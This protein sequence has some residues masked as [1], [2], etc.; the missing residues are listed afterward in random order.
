MINF[1]E[2]SNIIPAKVKSYDVSYIKLKQV[3]RWFIYGSKT[4]SLGP[5]CSFIQQPFVA[6]SSIRKTPRPYPLTRSS[7]KDS[8]KKFRSSINKIKTDNL[9][10][11]ES[12]CIPLEQ[13]FDNPKLTSHEEL[14]KPK[15]CP[16]IQH[17]RILLK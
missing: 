11:P 17:K 10:V 9:N 1:I 15:E 8:I 14:F 4:I 3:H 6:A 7:R 2:K 16:G 12:E 13:Y 5:C